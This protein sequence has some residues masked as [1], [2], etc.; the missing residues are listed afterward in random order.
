MAS[1]S[2]EVRINILLE[3]TECRKNGNPG[4][5]R[6]ASEKNKRNTTERLELKKF[7]KFDRKVTVFRETK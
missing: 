3:C 2:K 1:K 7:C 4:V 5:A 6:Y